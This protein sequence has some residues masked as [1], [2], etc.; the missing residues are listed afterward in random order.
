MNRRYH[1]LKEILRENRSSE[2]NNIEDTFGSETVH[3]YLKPVLHRKKNTTT[4]ATFINNINSN[5]SN[6]NN[7]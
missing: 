4:G 3:P 2:V 7:N 1:Y 6:I 5:N